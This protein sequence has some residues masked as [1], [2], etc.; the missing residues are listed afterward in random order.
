MNTKKIGLGL[1]LELLWFLI[2]AIV[3]YI[4]IWPVKDIISHEL[5]IYLLGT[6]FLIFT[7][8]RCTAFLQ[9]SILMES[10][11]SKIIIFILNFPLF[12]FMLNKSFK[13]S[14]VTEEY[15]FTLPKEEIQHI[16]SGTE[17]PDLMY[18]KHLVTIAEPA[19]LMLIILFQLRIMYAIFKLRQLDKV[20]YRNKKAS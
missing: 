14:R 4:I 6:Y 7:Y 20:I 19:V 1:L 3:A 5:Y 13:Y 17:L 18:I 16:K 12:F 8:F 9:H 10:I 15:I 11:W 2:A